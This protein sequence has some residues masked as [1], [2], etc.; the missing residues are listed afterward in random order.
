MV[1]AGDI[2]KP[3]ALVILDKISGWCAR[4]DHGWHNISQTLSK[5]SQKVNIIQGKKKIFRF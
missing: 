3:V 5:I 4:Q 2:L 1:G